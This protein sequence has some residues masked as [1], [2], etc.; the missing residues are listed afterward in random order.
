M[1]ISFLVL[2]NWCSAGLLYLDGNFFLYIWEFFFYAF[3]EN[4]LYIFGII[5]FLFFYAHKPKAR[6]FSGIL[7]LSYVP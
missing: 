6:S 5:F 2:S 1:G 3:I 4:I 7:N